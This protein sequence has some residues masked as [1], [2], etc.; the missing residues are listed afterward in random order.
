VSNLSYNILR[1]EEFHDLYMSLSLI[2]L[3]NSRRLRCA[4]H[5]GGMSGQ[6]INE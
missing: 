5:V 3:V 6:G 2:I 4:V 1:K